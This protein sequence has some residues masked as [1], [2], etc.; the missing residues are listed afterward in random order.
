V[1]PLGNYFTQI[2][3]RE[4][5]RE[6]GFVKAEHL[7]L[8]YDLLAGKSMRFHIETYLQRF[9]D[10]PVAKDTASSWSILNTIDGFAEY[11]MAN[12]GEGQNIG[13][14]VS[15]EKSFTGGIFFIL[16]GSVSRSRYKDAAGRE[17][18]TA[19][20]SGMAATFTGGKEWTF[21]NASV[22]QLGL[23]II[24]NGGQRLTPLLPDQPVNRFSQEPVLDENRAFEEQVEAYFRPD[25]RIAFRKNNPR[26]AWSLALD[27]QNIINRRNVDALNRTYDP[28]LNEWVYR[29]QSGLTPVLSFQIDL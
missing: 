29:E 3:G 13:L 27:I 9:R 5:S 28:D 20:D 14:D 19:F 4:V 10:V 21:Q 16:S 26:T 6:A 2:N 18:P 23:K 11:E 25:L 15:A 7:V 22:L 24:Y 1:L 12:A 17:H 8:G